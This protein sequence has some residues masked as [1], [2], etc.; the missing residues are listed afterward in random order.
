M[1]ALMRWWYQK[2]MEMLTGS[3]TYAER[4]GREAWERGD[5][6]AVDRWNKLKDDATKKMADVELLLVDA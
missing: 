2:R 4:K 1:N 6:K 3:M 5:I